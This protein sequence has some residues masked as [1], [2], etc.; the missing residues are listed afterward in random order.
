MQESF[1]KKFH[2]IES[3]EQAMILS[4]LQRLVSMM[5]AKS[6]SA[7]PFLTA[8]PIGVAGTQTEAESPGEKG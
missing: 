5:D 8:A 3:W 1:L 7:A 6:I 4:A 2:K